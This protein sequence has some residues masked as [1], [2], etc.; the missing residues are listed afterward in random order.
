MATGELIE[1]AA[2][3]MDNVAESIEEAA[4][5]TRTMDGRAVGLLFGGLAVGIG[6]GFG[7]GYLTQRKKLEAKYERITRATVDEMREHYRGQAVIQVPVKPDIN[8]VVEKL[9]YKEPGESGHVAYS[10]VERQ[11]IDEVAEEEART[12]VVESSESKNVFEDSQISEWD[13]ATEV[14]A[15][16]RFAPYIIH[17]DEFMQNETHHEQLSYTYWENDDILADERET[18]ITQLDEVV[19]LENLQKFGH[20]SGE[21]DVLYIRNEKLGVDI[22]INRSFGNFSEDVH[23]VIQ[24]SNERMYHHKPRFDDER[25]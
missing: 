19:G 20:G 9:G 2:D 10:E 24:H 3:H 16:T 25:D 14:K 4:D 22:E 12:V 1:S 11:A 23:G 15:R 5:V 21:S 17:K 13:Y 6:I 18:P 7:V 8:D